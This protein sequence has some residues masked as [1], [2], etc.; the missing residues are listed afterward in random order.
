MPT[1]V[2]QSVTLQSITPD[3][4]LL[5][6]QAGRCCYKSEGKTCPGSAAKM[7]AMLLKRGH[8]SVLEH[9]SATFLVTTDRGITHEMVRHRLASYSQESTR[10]VDYI[11]KDEG[12][13]EETAEISINVIPPLSLKEDYK[14]PL[15]LVWYRAMQSAENAYRSLRQNGCPPQVA[16]DVLPTCLK[17]DIWMTCN[18]REWRHFIKLRAAKAAHPKIQVIAKEVHRL[19]NEQAPNVFPMD[20]VE[21]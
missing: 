5:I 11:I 15:F 8:E 7:L 3:A 10:Y 21:A 6:E 4:E 18:F 1:I 20:M 12:D 16:R 19:L 2:P 14:D 9:A 17:A 13:P